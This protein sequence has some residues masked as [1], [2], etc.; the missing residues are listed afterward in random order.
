MKSERAWIVQRPLPKGKWKNIVAAFS[1]GHAR[2]LTTPER[3]DRIVE[4]VIVTELPDDAVSFHSVVANFVP[5]PG[6]EGACA[7]PPGKPRRGK[8]AKK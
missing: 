6:R 3:K 2:M 1:F 5:C 8:S 4:A 7:L